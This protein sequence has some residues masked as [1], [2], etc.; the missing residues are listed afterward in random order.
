MK[1]GLVPA[2]A[3]LIN[4]IDS[5]LKRQSLLRVPRF[6]RINRRAKPAGAQR[7]ESETRMT[8]HGDAPS[9]ARGSAMFPA[10]CPAVLEQPTR[11]WGARW[12]PS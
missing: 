3:L 4:K 8:Q 5:L 11:A 6:I 12:S 1:Q 2:I 10:C 9:R 7:P